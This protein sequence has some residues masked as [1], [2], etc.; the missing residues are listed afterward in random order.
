MWDLTCA[1]PHM[2]MHRL[3]Q[4]YK[5]GETMIW[6]WNGMSSKITYVIKKEPIIYG[7]ITGKTSVCRENG[8]EIKHLECLEWYLVHKLWFLLL[9]EE[10]HTLLEMMRPTFFFFGRFFFDFLTFPVANIRFYNIE[11]ESIAVRTQFKIDVA[12]M[13]IRVAALAWTHFLYQA[14]S[15][16]EV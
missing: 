1:H 10:K 15:H 5:D 9:L 12:D 2:C 11:S 3:T 14:G 13:C 7:V 16:V 6:D 8:E 4:K